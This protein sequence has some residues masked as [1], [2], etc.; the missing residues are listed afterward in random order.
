MRL[1][2]ESG[3]L[4]P[5]WLRSLNFFFAPLA[6]LA[7]ATSSSLV[8]C[9]SEAYKGYHYLRLVPNKEPQSVAGKFCAGDGTGI[10]TS[11][12]NWVLRV[13]PPPSAPISTHQ[14]HLKI[15][16]LAQDILYV[17][18]DW[19]LTYTLAVGIADSALL[20]QESGVRVSPRVPNV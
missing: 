2:W 11:L 7:E 10:R 3:P 5:V 16:Q 20:R 4:D 12:R 8:K 6:Q 17:Q 15:E 19:F 14:S 13:R 1:V 9:R 18:N